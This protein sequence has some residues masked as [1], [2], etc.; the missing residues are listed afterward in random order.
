MTL[1]RRTF[2]WTTTGGLVAFKLGSFAKDHTGATEIAITMDDPK[3]D[4]LAGMT[5]SEINRRI[6]TTLATARVQAALFVAGMRID[7]GAG[8]ALIHD[9][10]TP[11]MRSAITHIRTSPTTRR[12][13]VMRILPTTS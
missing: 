9:W 4:N 8:R 1:S 2:L 10:D 7:N 3:P 6:L 11:G 13:F 5:G 12:K